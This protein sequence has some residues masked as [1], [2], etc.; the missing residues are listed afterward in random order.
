MGHKIQPGLGADL[1]RQL[2]TDRKRY[3][4][5]VFERALGGELFRASWLRNSRVLCFTA[6]VGKGLR[7]LG[8]EGSGVRDMICQPCS[9]NYDD[10]GKNPEP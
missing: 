4:H 5:S 10:A 9:D 1:T 8:F 2:Y 7:G 6:F 3:S